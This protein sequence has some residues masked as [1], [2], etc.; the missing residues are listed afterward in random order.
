MRLLLVE[1]DSIIGSGLAQGLRLEGFIVDW[2]RDVKTAQQAL[3]LVSYG[4]LLLDLGLPQV[5]GMQILN[6]IRSA[7]SIL[8]VIVITARDALQDRLAGLNSGADDYLVKPFALEELVARIHAVSRRQNGRAE[9]VWTHGA[10]RIDPA[11]H[12]ALLNEVSIPVSAK[13]FAL[14][15]E[16]LHEPGIILSREQLEERL[17][18]WGDEIAS[19]AI[20]VHIHNL[21]KKFGQNII[22]TIRGVGYQIG[23]PI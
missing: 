14:L 17:Y 13:E 10:L 5:D 12:L 4:L 16:F 7:G 18:G 23:V 20:E 8:P 3:Q 11:R 19:N 2:V 21:R 1:D 15:K 22:R 9:T 6:N